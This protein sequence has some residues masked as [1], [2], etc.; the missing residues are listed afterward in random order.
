MSHKENQVKK[1]RHL[2][3]SF[4]AIFP[5]QT[6]YIF[7]KTQVDFAWSGL[8][9]PVNLPLLQQGPLM[10]LITAGS[11]CLM[12]LA[13][14]KEPFES[15]ACWVIWPVVHSSAVYN[16]INITF[17]LHWQFN[18]AIT[19]LPR[20]VNVCTR[21][22]N[23]L[24]LICLIYLSFFCAPVEFKLWYLDAPAQK[25]PFAFIAYRLWHSSPKDASFFYLHLYFLFL[26][27]IHN[28]KKIKKNK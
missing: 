4:Q 27:S 22:R 10:L 9:I 14:W 1:S 18:A 11:H 2:N 20:I 6:T 7:L 21:F 16:Q 3:Q 5:W 8:E 24:C 25:N 15:W 17:L 28:F 26:S 12:M 23:E 13:D 19:D